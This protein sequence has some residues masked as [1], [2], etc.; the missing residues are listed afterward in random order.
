MIK[1]HVSSSALSMVNPSLVV[2]RDTII[3]NWPCVHTCFGRYKPTCLVDCPWL[4]LIVMEKHGIKGSCRLLSLS[5]RLDSLGDMIVFGIVTVA[6]TYILKIIWALLGHL[7]KWVTI[8][9]V[10][11][12]RPSAWFKFL[13]SIIGYPFF[14][15]NS[16]LG[17]L[18]NFKLWKKFSW[19]QKVFIICVHAYFADIVWTKIC[20]PF[21]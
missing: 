15:R 12:H 16:W 5:D 19:V 8:N 13:W 2:T 14:K 7:S 21:T 4:L 18:E 17:M 9:L 6:P 20:S 3:Y 11:L 10:P 1:S